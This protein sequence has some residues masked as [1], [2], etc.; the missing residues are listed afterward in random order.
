MKNSVKYG[1][2]LTP[3]TDVPWL[4]KSSLHAQ[5]VPY[6]SLSLSFLHSGIILLLGKQPLL[7]TA[8]KTNIQFMITLN[9]YKRI[10]A[11]AESRYNSNILLF[12]SLWSHMR[13]YTIM[14]VTCLYH[15]CARFFLKNVHVIKLDYNM[16][17]II[18]YVQENTHYKTMRN[19]VTHSGMLNNHNDHRDSGT[20]PQIAAHVSDPA[21][22]FKLIHFCS[23]KFS[24]LSVSTASKNIIIWSSMPTGLW[25]FS[26]KYW[27]C[28]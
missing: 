19:N 10:L 20:G 3:C 17:N 21:T 1:Y 23:N 18:M 4:Q 11:N 14:Y 9:V 26:W 22:G 24:V 7:I 8:N 12:N 16:H 28:F 6:I 2:K 15:D 13:L 25:L 27:I 5:N